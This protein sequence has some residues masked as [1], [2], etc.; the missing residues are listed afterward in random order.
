[1]IKLYLPTGHLK[2]ETFNL[3]KY[4]GNKVTLSQKGRITQIENLEFPTK[5]V[6]F[7]DI[8]LL[9]ALQKADAGLTYTDVLKEFYLAHPNLAIK[10]AVF[11]H[12][13]LRNTK[14]SFV[15]SNDSFPLVTTFSEFL[16]KVRQQ[17]RDDV[18]IAT[19]HP[20]TVQ[21]F[22]NKK[23]ITRVKILPT[24]GTALNWILPP[25]P[26]ADL[27]AI[28]VENGQTLAENNCQIIATIQENRLALV[29]NRVSLEDN[30]KRNKI[31]ELSASL[32][33]SLIRISE[34]EQLKVSQLHL[35]I[36]RPA[37]AF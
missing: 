18:I 11:S 36:T 26:E 14:L 21:L 15:I 29:V 37:P 25:D 8:P 13:P 24:N 3:L 9:L 32:R 17:K 20:K 30:L 7:K 1:M 6:S 2:E 31:E 16:G 35:P 23:G 12:I 5:Y 34:I 28:N 27:A 33:R 10:L 4:A 22:L 19:G